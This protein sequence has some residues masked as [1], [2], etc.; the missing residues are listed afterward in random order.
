MSPPTLDAMMPRASDDHLSREQWKGFVR[1]VLVGAL[2]SLIYLLTPLQTEF[3]WLGLL[4]GLVALVC[5]APFAYKRAQAIGRSRF[6]VLAAAE[7]I[8]LVAAMLI[9][10]FSSV[11]LAVDRHAGQ[12]E[13]IETRIDAFYFTVTTLST[14]GYGDIHATGQSAR[15]LV[16]MQILFDLSLLAMS[17]R[18]LLGAAK[19][20]RT[21]TV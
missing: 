17:V 11:Y 20:G 13:G 6:P 7:A 3:A 8:L 21:P 14:V 5:I 16:T 19:Q 15:L 1:V 2:L 9:F 10:G 12:F 4:I 18:L